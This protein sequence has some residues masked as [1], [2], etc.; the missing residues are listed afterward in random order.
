MG[1]IGRPETSVRNN[2]ST[3]RNIPEEPS[4]HIR[5][6]GS[7]KSRTVL[8]ISINLLHKLDVAVG[9]RR[10]MGPKTRKFPRFIT[11][12]A[13]RNAAAFV[14]SSG[15]KTNDL[16]HIKTSLWLVSL[17]FVSHICAVSYQCAVCLFNNKSLTLSSLAATQTGNIETEMPICIWDLNHIII[18]ITYCNWVFT[19]WE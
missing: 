7:L 8:K 16:L 10:I 6:G 2:H 1:P 18:I 13:W 14:A 15:L 17:G 11:F 19:R 5:R 4:S 12:Y 3:P 9:W